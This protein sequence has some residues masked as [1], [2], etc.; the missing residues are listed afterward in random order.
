MPLSCRVSVKQ[1]GKLVK[2]A[3]M[4]VLAVIVSYIDI[5]TSV[6]VGREYLENGYTNL[7]WTVIGIQV[8]GRGR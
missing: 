7:G 1:E 3:G 8:S 2:A 6:G 4:V 5:G